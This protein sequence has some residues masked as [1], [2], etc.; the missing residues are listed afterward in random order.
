MDTLHYPQWSSGKTQDLCRVVVAQ[1]SPYMN[2]SLYAQ[3]FP[4]LKLNFTLYFI[5]SQKV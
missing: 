4:Y 3:E 5:N 1:T 2:I